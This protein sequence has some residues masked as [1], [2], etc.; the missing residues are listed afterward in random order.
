VLGAVAIGCVSLTPRQQDTLVD[1]QRFADATAAA[2]GMVRIRV[3]VQP[4]TNLGI[5]AVYRQGNFYLNAD[6]LDSGHLTALVA[7][8]LAHY[9]LGHEPTSGVSMAELLKAQE[10]RELD[11]NAKAVEIMVRAKGMTRP[12]AVRTMVVFLRTAQNAQSR[13]RPNAP[14]HPPPAEEIADLLARF[15]TSST[16]A[17]EQVERSGSPWAPIS[18]PTWTSGDQWTFWWDDPR[19][20][21]TYVWSVD[22]EQE[23]DGTPCYV[24][25]SRATA[26][27][28]AREFFF[29]KS[30]LAWRMEMVSGTVESKSEPPQLR[31]V[32]PLA[33][34]G[35][36]E[37]T[38]T[39]TTGRGEK[40]TTERRTRSCRVA[41]EETVTVAGGVFRTLKT[42][43]LD[44][45]NQV[46]AEMWYAPEVK[47]WVK[48]WVRFPWGVRERELM[49]AK[50][51]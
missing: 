45:T 31:Y 18:V 25:V 13:G 1:V 16:P 41:G 29:Q 3:N 39:L 37:Q 38:V 48:E 19:S 46:V 11:A 34:G 27:Q 8:E 26:S 43:C 28:P 33:I 12:Q 32:W 24:V 5:G 22:R 42:V 35:A 30:D 51:R 20:S 10:L 17:A 50:L 14:G 36:W 23:V 40:S 49:G 47:F 6:T 44:Q 15:P 9:V 4:G 21:G 7:H 2:Y